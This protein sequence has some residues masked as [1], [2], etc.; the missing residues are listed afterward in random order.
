MIRQD[1]RLASPSR[2][3]Q[4]AEL[5]H[6]R[7]R[8]PLCRRRR[9]HRSRWTLMWRVLTNESAGGLLGAPNC[10]LHTIKERP[11]LQECKS[12]VL[13]LLELLFCL[14]REHM[15]TGSSPERWLH[16]GPPP[17]Y[18]PQLLRQRPTAWSQWMRGIRLGAAP[19]PSVLEQ[20][21]AITSSTPV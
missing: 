8:K 16:T 1:P 5:R 14:C 9:W 15:S 2:P 10:A 21:G 20:S 6:R 11:G 17:K 4:R 7:R 18:M 13:Q 3:P 12:C 19:D